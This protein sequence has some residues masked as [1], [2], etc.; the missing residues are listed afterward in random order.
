MTN[1]ANAFRAQMKRPD[2]GASVVLT[3]ASTVKIKP[4]DWLWEGFLPAGMLTLLA[5]L[6]GCGKSTLALAMAAT[7]TNA[8]RWP[9]GTP[10]RRAGSVLVWS[11]RSEE[12]RVG[13]EC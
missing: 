8:G 11:S 4:V 5:G 7:I 6:P 9:D 2:A 12:R 3:T 13:K 1:A 10:M